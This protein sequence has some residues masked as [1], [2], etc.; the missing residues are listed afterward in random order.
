MEIV[1]SERDPWLL[2]KKCMIVVTD[3]L[4]QTSTVLPLVDA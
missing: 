1:S 4:S 2:I 3:M